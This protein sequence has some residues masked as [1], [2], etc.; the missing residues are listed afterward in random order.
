VRGN[1]KKRVKEGLGDKK[2]EEEIEGRE[3]GSVHER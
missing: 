1:G 3:A 2:R